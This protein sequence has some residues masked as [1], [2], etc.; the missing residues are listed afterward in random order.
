MWTILFFVGL[1][2]VILSLVCM[3]VCNNVGIDINAKLL[4]IIIVISIILMIPFFVMPRK[5]SG[6]SRSYNYDDT[7]DRGF[8]GSDGKYHAYVPEFGDDVNNW[9]KE[10]W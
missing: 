2:G 10:N 9:M 4:C 1:I 7:P 6:S 3:M 8:V 5:S